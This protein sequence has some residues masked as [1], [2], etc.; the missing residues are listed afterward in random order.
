MSARIANNRLRNLALAIG[1]LAFAALFALL[2]WSVWH[3]DDADRKALPSTL[4]GRPAPQFD[5]PL[6]QDPQDASARSRLETGDLRGAPFVL[7][8]WGSW[9]VECRV[10]QPALLQLASAQQVKLVGYN[11]KDEP[12]DAQ[13]W[14]RQNGN[15]YGVIVSDVDGHAALDWG[16]YG[17]P[18]TFLVDGA[19]I[20]RWKH[21]GPLD[22]A[23]VASEL[24][25]QLDALERAR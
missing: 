15:P 9:C 3:S 18:E 12:G 24:L 6:L 19:G 14:L 25:P 4:I 20:V 2:A 11:L 13:H 22:A 23:I 10:E 1:A 16:I 17:A 7:N 5:L 21:V 8:V